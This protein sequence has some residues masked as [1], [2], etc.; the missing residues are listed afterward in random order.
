MYA[1]HEWCIIVEWSGHWYVLLV[2]LALGISQVELIEHTVGPVLSQRAPVEFA[3]SLA[4]VEETMQIG[5]CR[6]FLS[7][8]HAHSILHIAGRRDTIEGI[9]NRELLFLL[10][11]ASKAVVDMIATDGVLLIANGHHIDTLAWS[12]IELP[13]VL[14]DSCYNVVVSKG[15]PLAHVAVFN[16]EICIFLS[17]AEVADGI[18]HKDAGMRFTTMVHNLALIVNQV[19]NAEGRR[20]HLARSSEM[21]ELAT[22]QRYDGHRELRE[23]IVRR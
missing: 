16:P 5:L 17:K 1:S 9:D 12:Q 8:D 3:E 18:L 19:L 7:R 14:W 15:P 10:L 13:I 23:L 11:C 6:Y 22:L 4:L 21:V 20:N 2:E